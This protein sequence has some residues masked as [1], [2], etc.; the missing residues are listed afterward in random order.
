MAFEFL[1]ELQGDQ[2]AGVLSCHDRL[3]I[4]NS[5]PGWHYAAGAT[6]SRA[7]PFCAP[8]WQVL[9]SLTLLPR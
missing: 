7:R 5:L 6:Q 1:I 9:A 4:Q 2:I 3:L 8:P